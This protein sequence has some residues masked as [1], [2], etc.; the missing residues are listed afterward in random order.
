MMLRRLFICRRDGSPPIIIGAPT[1]AAA[2]AIASRSG[3]AGWAAEG[4]A[5]SKGSDTLWKL[6]VGYHRGSIVQLDGSRTTL[7]AILDE[8]NGGLRAADA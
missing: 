4:L 2:I 7:G 6:P 3:D 5:M 1:Q 8:W